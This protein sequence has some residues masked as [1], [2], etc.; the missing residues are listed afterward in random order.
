MNGL[1]SSGDGVGRTG[2]IT[3]CPGGDPTLDGADTCTQLAAAAAA[4][5]LVLA[6]CRSASTAAWCC[7]RKEASEGGVGWGSGPQLEVGGRP[8]PG[9][10]PPRKGKG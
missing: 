3:V 10:G 6:C 8:D 9:C 5:A 4:A 1:C 7:M 2:P